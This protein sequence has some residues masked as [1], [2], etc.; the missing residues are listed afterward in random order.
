LS[1]RQKQKRKVT[2]SYK[3]KKDRC[4]I[5]EAILL[6]KMIR[7]QEQFMQ[8]I[9]LI[10]HLGKLIEKVESLGLG[11]NFGHLAKAT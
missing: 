2:F 11:S 9:L 1:K 3:T 6:C 8:L 4:F 5:T 7:L 10:E